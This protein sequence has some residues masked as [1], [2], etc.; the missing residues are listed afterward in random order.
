[1]LDNYES[2]L[3]ELIRANNDGMEMEKIVS[4]FDTSHDINTIIQAINKLSSD[5]LIQ[6]L[7]KNGHIYY[8]AISDPMLESG[9]RLIFECIRAAGD[10]GIWTKDLKA[11]TCIHQAVMTK[12]IRSLESKRLIKSVKN[13]KNPT[14]K[15]LML[16][17][18]VP[19]SEVTGGPWFDE[20]ELDFE[21]INEICNVIF[22]FFQSKGNKPTVGCD[23]TILT[24]SQIHEFI[25]MSKITTV[26]LAINDVVFL[27]NKLIYDGLIC[28]YPVRERFSR[29]DVHESSFAD[30]QLWGCSFTFPENSVLNVPCSMCPSINDCCGDGHITPDSCQYLH[31]WLKH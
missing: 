24:V 2:T 22:R 9:E 30:I 29:I 1:M 10:K 8:K 27:L 23:D 16:F 19:S 7:N 6:V 31:T 20:S 18:T 15:I 5:G 17:D 12:I 4:S 3:I 13:T 28:I 26:T 25:Q 11:K 21:F 14:R